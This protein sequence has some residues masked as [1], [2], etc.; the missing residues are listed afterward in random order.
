MM[1]ED[2]PRSEAGIR[3]FV[4]TVSSINHFLAKLDPLVYIP[5]FQVGKILIVPEKKTLYHQ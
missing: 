2:G 5:L 4:D 3:K 1:Q